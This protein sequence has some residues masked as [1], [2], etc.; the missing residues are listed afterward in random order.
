MPRPDQWYLDAL[1]RK[2]RA[3]LTGIYIWTGMRFAF[4]VAIFAAAVM[5]VVRLI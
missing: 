4:F 1:E 2:R 3:E 5:I